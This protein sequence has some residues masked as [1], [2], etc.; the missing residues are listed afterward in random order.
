MTDK[1]YQVLVFDWDGTLVDSTTQIAEAILRAAADIGTPVPD[2][3]Q[4]SLVIGLGLA[5][6]LARVVPDL[7]PER[8]PEFAARYR[9]HYQ[10]SE[11]HIRLFDGALAMLDTL[12]ERGVPLAIATGKT[13]AGLARALQS[14]RLEE[15]FATVRCADQT[16]P[17]PHPAM[18]QELAIEFAVDP[19]DMLMIG[20][21]AHD[22]QMAG[23]A[24]VAAVGVSYGAHPRAELERL[25]PLA[26]FDT[27][28]ALQRWLLA[29]C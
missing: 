20:D 15:H 14:A 2:R 4:A 17:K 19:A 9:A 12:R 28:P 16:Q 23:S 6:A 3:A 1:R 29:H 25:Q 22:L 27:L 21:T 10:Y 5:Q 7:P 18:L 26:I 24:G 8:I 11:Q 13:H